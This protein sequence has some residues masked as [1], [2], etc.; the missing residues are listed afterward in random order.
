MLLFLKQL[1][2]TANELTD[3]L[4][5]HVTLGLPSGIQQIELESYKAIREF[6]GFFLASF[7]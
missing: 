6:G 1:D 4:K 3:I 2:H 7:L 5:V